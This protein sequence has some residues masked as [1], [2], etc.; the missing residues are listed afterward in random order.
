[1]GD[2]L[3]HLI[4]MLLRVAMVC[5]AITLLIL[6]V[7]YVKNGDLYIARTMKNKSTISQKIYDET[8]NGETKEMRL[9]AGNT[10]HIYITGSEMV[11]S[12]LNIYKPG[13]Q[14][15]I[16]CVSPGYTIIYNPNVAAD[17]EFMDNVL[18]YDSNA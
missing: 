11:S 15:K 8:K 1:M 5:G 2:N 14:V 10:E 12:I 7:D 3:S 13:S 17:I 16:S 6:S 4:E 9:D 18:Q